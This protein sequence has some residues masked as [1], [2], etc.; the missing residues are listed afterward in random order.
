MNF[1][2]AVRCYKAPAA[3]GR[4]R[5]REEQAQSW[6]LFCSAALKAVARVAGRNVSGSSAP[7]PG[8][9]LARPG[10]AKLFLPVPTLE[11]QRAETS[12]LETAGD[13]PEVH[14]TDEATYCSY[15][16]TGT[17][18]GKPLQ[19][20]GRGLPW[21]TGHFHSQL[22]PTSLWKMGGHAS[23]C[24][25]EAHVVKPCPVMDVGAAGPLRAEG[26]KVLDEAVH[27]G[28]RS[29]HRSHE[30]ARLGCWCSTRQLHSPP[31]CPAA[32]QPLQETHNS[33]TNGN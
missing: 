2:G 3:Q 8:R 22:W 10:L 4:V 13:S 33:S 12:P 9:R 30:Q 16:S 15:L 20:P 18:P 27:P 29:C 5:G 21:S 6:V 31:A 7:V 25:G 14:R 11:R 23:C 19:S 26:T 32:F 1:C 28:M 17:C 24:P